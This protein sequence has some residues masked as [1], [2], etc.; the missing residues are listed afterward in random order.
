[1]EKHP[2]MMVRSHEAGVHHVRTSNGNYAFL[3]ESPKND[4]IS[5][6]CD[7]MKIGEN[8]DSHGFGVGTPFGLPL[9][10]ILFLSS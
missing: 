9:R 4:F 5:E 1:M 2:E 6:P 3:I 10:L 7:T 8:L